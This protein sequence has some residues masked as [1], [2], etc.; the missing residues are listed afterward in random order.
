VGGAT[1]LNL[2]RDAAAR[3]VQPAFSPDGQHIAFRSDR[4]RALFVMGAT[5]E[6]PRRLAPGSHP[7]WSPDGKQ[8]AASTVN[9]GEPDSLANASGELLVIEV[10]TGSTRVVGGAWDVHQPNWS[11]H[12]NRVAY[13]GRPR[14]S[15]GQALSAQRDLW[16]ISP[17]GGVPVQVTNDSYTDWNP[18]WSN[19]G[20]WLFF[21]SNRD[22]SM[23]IW[24]VRMN[25]A[26]GTP[27]GQ[28]EPLTT[29]SPY[30]GFM[31]VSSDGGRI[32]YTKITLSRSFQTFQL[33][34]RQVPSDVPKAVPLGSRPVRS[35]DMSTDGNWIVGQIQQE[36][37]QEDLFVV[38]KDGTGF[39]KLTADRHRDR[40]P[41]WSP[42]GKTIAFFSD[43]SGTFQIWLIEANGNGLRQFTDADIVMT[44]PIWSGTGSR[45][46][47]RTPAT[48]E[49]PVRV[50]VLD[51][52][53]EW[54]EQVP[55]VLPISLA[56]AVDVTPT[57]WS[58]D[59]RQLALNAS[60]GSTC[61]YDFDTRRIRQ[62]WNT[63]TTARW[64]N[65]GRRLLVSRAGIL[66][67]LDAIS[68]KEQEVW[69]SPEAIGD[70]SLSSDDRTIVYVSRKEISEIWLAI[71]GSRQA[72]RQ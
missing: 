57:S 15:R 72:G 7:A 9:F 25:E 28:P 17:N 26:L 13:W 31:S 36:A 56:Q 20:R 40:S 10:A 52:R 67:V 51:A 54:N 22:G 61:V 59:E 65:D 66:Q 39:L 19:D 41:R 2:T 18:V 8:I 38:R 55:E 49:G 46:A 33:D 45:I 53:K 34:R 24:Q 50:L 21:C 37:G 35:P 29:P 42:D 58:K 47:V 32:A 11:P 16:T 44:D 69:K 27:Q 71:A 48:P 43:R 14:G 30:S 60:S 5:G 1:A 3:N 62:V 63:P 12:G 6:N 64:F 68:L 23:N 4:D 70:Y